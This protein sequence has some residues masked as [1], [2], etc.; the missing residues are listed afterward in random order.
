MNPFE[1]QGQGQITISEEK[2]GINKQLVRK[3]M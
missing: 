2:P 1:G 3:K